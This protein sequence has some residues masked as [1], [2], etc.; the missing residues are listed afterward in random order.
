M[1]IYKAAEVVGG[2]GHAGLDDSPQDG[3]ESEDE[4][5]SPIFEAVAADGGVLNFFDEIFHRSFSFLIVGVSLLLF[6]VGLLPTDTRGRTGAYA[7]AR[8]SN[9]FSR[10]LDSLLSRVFTAPPFFWL[11]LVTVA[12]VV[13][14]SRYSER[15]IM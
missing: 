7:P 4:E 6:S 1:F 5:G 2:R 9:H 13:V 10:A 11:S 8:S 12:K 14:N 15:F 3:G